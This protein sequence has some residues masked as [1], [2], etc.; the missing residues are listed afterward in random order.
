[1]LVGAMV[2]LVSTAVGAVAAVVVLS[3]LKSP[4]PGMIAIAVVIVL[5]P[6]MVGS[7]LAI[8]RRSPPVKGFGLGLLIGWALT[9]IV[10]GGSC[11]AQFVQTLG[12][13]G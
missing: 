4:Q 13:G 6:L 5:W 9:L 12:H 8:G 10:G 11:V 7:M 2:G 1:V 3:E